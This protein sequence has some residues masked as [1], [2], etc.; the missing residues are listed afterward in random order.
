MKKKL[1]VLA[2]MLISGIASAQFTIWEDDFDDADVSDWTLVDADGD[3]VNWITRTNIQIDGNGAVADGTYK[4]LG[5]Y[6]IDMASGSPL[7]VEQKNWAITPEMDLSFYGGSIQLIVNAQKAIFDETDNLYVYASTT[8]TDIASFTQVGALNMIRTNDNLLDVL[9]KDYVL[10]ISQFAG[11]SKVYFAFLNSKTLNVGYEIDK[12]SITATSLGIDDIAGK[13]K[14]FLKQNPV[15]NYLNLQ[16]S[17]AVI[18]EDLKL[19]VYNTAG[20]LVKESKYNEAGIA[21][22]NLQ[23]GV[24]FLVIENGKLTEKI[25]FIK[26]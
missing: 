9:F 23:S 16:L 3:A 18:A 7:G 6:N 15:E 13:N 24:Y 11:K 21:V 14:T 12:V 17:D 4:I 25:K 19:K 8:N 10:D 22:D 26:K 5:T 1:L 2:F 20:L